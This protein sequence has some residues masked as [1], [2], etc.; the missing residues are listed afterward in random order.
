ML[1]VPDGAAQ[2]IDSATDVRLVQMRK[3]VEDRG[4]LVSIELAHAH[5]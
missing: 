5:L 3:K 2:H 4:R 1:K